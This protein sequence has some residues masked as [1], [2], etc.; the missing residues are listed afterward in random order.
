MDGSDADLPLLRP[1]SS[2]SAR[3]AFACSSLASHEHTRH[4]GQ[5]VS[6]T[7]SSVRLRPI[8]RRGHQNGPGSGQQSDL[9][10]TLMHRLQLPRYATLCDQVPSEQAGRVVMGKY[11]GRSS[12]SV[13]TSETKGRGSRPPDWA[14][15]TCRPAQCRADD[16]RH[17]GENFLAP[18]SRPTF[19][20]LRQ[21]AA[22]R[23]IR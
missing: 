9:A 16:S 6:S 22:Q 17:R 20:S 13:A 10:L 7:V 23:W 11:M 8:R 4:A 18:P 1:G 2:A 3:I 15:H 19:S 21:R 12:P 14:M 5:P